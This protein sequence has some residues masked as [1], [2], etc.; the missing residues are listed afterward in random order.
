MLDLFRTYYMRLCY[1]CKKLSETMV[2]EPFTEANVNAHWT[3]MVLPQILL[4]VLIL[5]KVNPKN[6]AHEYNNAV[7]FFCSKLL[8]WLNRKPNHII[9]ASVCEPPTSEFNISVVRCSINTRWYSFSQKHCT[10]WIISEYR[11]CTLRC[12]VAQV[13]VRG[14]RPIV[15]FVLPFSGEES[16]YVY[17]AKVICTH[18][19]LYA[20]PTASVDYSCIHNCLT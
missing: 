3:G 1:F 6:C 7:K 2:R 4:L 8:Y 12:F 13:V 14:G 20:R 19:S 18:W 10:L 9:E 11:K 5:Q 15:W 17:T 16:S